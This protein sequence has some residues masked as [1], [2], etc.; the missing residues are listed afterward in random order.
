VDDLEQLKRALARKLALDRSGDLR[1]RSTS[2][3]PHADDLRFELDGRD[4]AKYGSQGQV[5]SLILSFKIA[6]V[7]NA[8]QIRQEYPVLLLD[9]VSSELDGERNG[10]LFDFLQRISCQVFLSTARPELLP[11]KEKLNIFQVVSGGIHPG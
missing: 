3:G 8:F 2:T 4:A 10:Y 5:R 11:L 1:R 7:L 9:D 6:Q